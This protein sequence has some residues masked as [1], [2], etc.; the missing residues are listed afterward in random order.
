VTA[1]H[2]NA[3]TDSKPET[4][5]RVNR[6]YL[7]AASRPLD[8]NSNRGF[9]VLGL[10]FGHFFASCEKS[11][12]TTL[13]KSWKSHDSRDLTMAAPSCFAFCGFSD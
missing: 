4:N 9:A 12:Q 11:P 3:Q 8:S 2:A 7:A 13:V 10:S 1:A 6:R 5:Q